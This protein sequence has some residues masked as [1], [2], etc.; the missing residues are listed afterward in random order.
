[1]SVT[2]H[3]THLIRSCWQ[4]KLRPAFSSSIESSGDPPEE[5]RVPSRCPSQSDCSFGT[6]S[7]QSSWSGPSFSQES[8]LDGLEVNNGEELQTFMQKMKNG[9]Q[10]FLKNAKMGSCH[11]LQQDWGLCTANQ[12]LECF[13]NS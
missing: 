3:N 13:P 6:L 1:M 7:S 11:A 9:L 10:N 5:E 2:G 12:T 4:Q 8:V